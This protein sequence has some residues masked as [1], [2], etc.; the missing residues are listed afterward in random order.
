MSVRAPVTPVTLTQYT[1]PA[2]PAHAERSRASVVVGATS[3]ISARP[4]ACSVARTPAASSA[5]RSGMMAPSSP[6]AAASAQ[7]DSMPYASTGLR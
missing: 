1:N 7:N 2:A 6:A 5:G 3:G 4:A